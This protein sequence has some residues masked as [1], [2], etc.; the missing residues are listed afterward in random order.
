VQGCSPHLV[1]DVVHNP[2]HFLHKSLEVSRA[3]TAAAPH[4]HSPHTQTGK[5]GARQQRSMHNTWDYFP[6][7]ECNTH[8]ASQS[9]LKNSRYTRPYGTC[10]CY[11]VCVQVQ[12]ASKLHP[13]CQAM[14][15][16]L[17]VLCVFVC[18]RKA[19]Y[20]FTPHPAPLTRTSRL[21]MAPRAAAPTGSN[22][23]ASSATLGWNKG[24]SMTTGGSRGGTARVARLGGRGRGGG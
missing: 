24:R 14:Y 3:W 5:Q 13:R 15:E 12:G 10:L 21:E 19:M 8:W 6:G 11:K 17:C 18:R 9:L 7:C 16:V 20:F 1:I 4:T 22:L 23:S 2:A